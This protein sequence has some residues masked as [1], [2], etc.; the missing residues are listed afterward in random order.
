MNIE[1]GYISAAF[2]SIKSDH[3]S[4]QCR[5]VCVLE[6][7]RAP[8][9]VVQR[10]RRRPAGSRLHGQRGSQHQRDETTS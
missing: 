8:R 3:N 9:L 10:S 2:T 6:R 1:L 5:N 4:L 7:V